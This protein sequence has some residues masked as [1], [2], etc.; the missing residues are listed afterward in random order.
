MDQI[1][2]WNPFQNEPLKLPEDY[3][4]LKALTRV[5]GGDA[6]RQRQAE[7]EIVPFNRMV[8]AWLLAISLGARARDEQLPYQPAT[9]RFEYG[10]RLHGDS[11]A[12]HF[13]HHVAL[14][15]LLRSGS[16]A[17]QPE[18]AAYEIVE[19]PARVV[20]I[21]NDYAARGMPILREMTEDGTLGPLPALLRALTGLIHA[22][23]GEHAGGQDQI[24]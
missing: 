3:E 13:L 5:A 24:A 6:E 16:Y 1:G 21:C 23:D 15:E 4:W 20:E 12:I 18:E 11:D 2:G 7:S 22:P 14:S 17:T 19:N 8:D 10:A 9:H